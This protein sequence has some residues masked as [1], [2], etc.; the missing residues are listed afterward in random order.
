VLLQFTSQTSVL[1]QENKTS[2]ESSLASNKI[3]DTLKAEQIISPSLL[4]YHYTDEEMAEFEEAAK[5]DLKK[6]SLKG[7]FPA[8]SAKRSCNV[9]QTMMKYSFWMVIH[10]WWLV[11]LTKENN[12][13]ELKEFN[14]R[15]T[16]YVASVPFVCFAFDSV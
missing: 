13:Y 12:K 4:G 6:N 5:H 8:V 11:S 10:T 9:R 7:L 15:I 14:V 3:L 1:R 2:T 16:F